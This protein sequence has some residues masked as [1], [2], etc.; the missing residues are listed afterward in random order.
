MTENLFWTNNL[1]SQ[2]EREARLKQKG[3][4]IW[5][6]GLSA[7]GKSTVARTLERK[8]FDLGYL[9]FVLDGDNIRQGLSSNLGFSPE[10]RSE[11]IRRIAELANLFSMAGMINIAAFISPYRRE[12]NLAR[13]LAKNGNFVE[14]YVNTPVEVCMQRDPKGLYQRALKGEIKNFTGID[15][16]Y[17]APEKPDVVIKTNI[18]SVEECVNKILNYL[19]DK[20][21]IM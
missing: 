20:Q 14:V 15:A 11:N 18:E 10:D 2:E 6:T 19:R 4:T 3:V 1:V 8:L 7:S 21:F 17:E 16:P 5:L 12:R 13:K 9:T